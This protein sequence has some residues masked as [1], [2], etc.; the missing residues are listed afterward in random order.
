MQGIERKLGEGA[1]EGSEVWACHLPIVVWLD[2][3]G[4]SVLAVVFLQVFN[5]LVERPAGAA[6]ADAGVDNNMFHQLYNYT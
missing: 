3:Y 6:A 1:G 2:E 5:K 4:I